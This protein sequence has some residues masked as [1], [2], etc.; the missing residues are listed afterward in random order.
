M[1]LLKVLLIIVILIVLAFPYLPLDLPFTISHY[2]YP[3]EER[4]KNLLNLFALLLLSLAVIAGMPL[5]LNLA[6]GFF[7]LRPVAWFASLLPRFV[8]YDIVLA[9]AVFAN[10]FYVLVCLIVLGIV[11]RTTGLISGLRGT[12]EER[13][14]RKEARRKAREEKKRQ[15]EEEKQR[16]KQET[17]EKKKKAEEEKKKAEEEKKKA[18]EEKKKAEQKKQKA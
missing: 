13:Q 17:E 14:A 2:N 16:K 1:L 12:A 11:G 8:A 15:R 18:E 4:P 10:V 6:G 9:K 7:A 3:P 5:V